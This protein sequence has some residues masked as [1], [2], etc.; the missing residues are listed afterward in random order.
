MKIKPEV[1]RDLQYA[2][3]HR[4]PKANILNFIRECYLNRDPSIPGIDKTRNLEMRFRWDLL[5]DAGILV[6]YK[7]YLDATDYGSYPNKYL[8]AVG[9]G[10]NDDH[11]DTALKRIVKNLTW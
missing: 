8:I 1:L 3:K 10:V 2:I 9:N 7:E 11:I 6:M 4:H 5:H